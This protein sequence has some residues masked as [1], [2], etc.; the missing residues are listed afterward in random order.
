MKGSVYLIHFSEPFGHAR[1][2]IGWAK[3]LELR[4][5]HH[6]N[7]NGANLL[8]KVNEA[9]ITWEVTR[10]WQDVDRNFERSL[11]RRKEAPRLCPICVAAGTERCQTPLGQVKAH[12]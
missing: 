7:G 9:G 11:K 10:V 4:L 2:Y 6:R 1:H 8:A 5:N 3:H 12:A